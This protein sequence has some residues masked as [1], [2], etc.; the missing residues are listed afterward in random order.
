MSAEPPE[1]HDADEMERPPTPRVERRHVR[2]PPCAG[3]VQVSATG[4]TRVTEART[5]PT[6]VSQ[7]DVLAALRVFQPASVVSG[8]KTRIGSENDGGYVMLDDLDRATTAFSLGILDDDNWDV[9]V[10]SRGIVV[11]QYDDSIEHAPSRHPKLQFFRSRIGAP[12]TPGTVSLQGI[13]GQH[14][15]GS[16]A[17]LILKMD[18]EGSE[19]EVLEMVPTDIL[20]RFAQIV[21]ELHDLERMAERDL[22]TVAMAALTKL[23]LTHQAIHLHGNNNT[24]IRIIENVAFP[25]VVEVSFVARSLYEFEPCTEVFPTDLDRPNHPARSDLFLGRSFLEPSV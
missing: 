17:D 7:A 6:R 13:V 25:G 1:V 8:R 10:A 23:S 24:P 16:G 11:K 20:S 15:T 12:E 9:A 14:A 21:C 19:W 5:N 3:F 22:H 18:I 2:R 4:R